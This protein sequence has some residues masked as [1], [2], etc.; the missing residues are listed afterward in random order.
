MGRAAFVKSGVLGTEAL[1]GFIFD[2]KAVVDIDG[3]ESHLNED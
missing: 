3:L 1:C 2:F